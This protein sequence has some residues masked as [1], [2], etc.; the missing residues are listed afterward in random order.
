MTLLQAGLP[1]LCL[2]FKQVYVLTHRWIL[3]FSGWLHP[4][5]RAALLVSSCRYS[6]VRTAAVSCSF[7]PTWPSSSPDPCTLLHPRRRF[8]HL[9]SCVRMNWDQLIT[10]SQTPGTWSSADGG[11]SPSDVASEL[12]SHLVVSHLLFLS[13]TLQSVFLCCFCQPD[14]SVLRKNSPSVPHCRTS[15]SAAGSLSRL[16]Q[17]I[18][19]SIFKIRNSFRVLSVEQDINTMQSQTFTTSGVI[20]WF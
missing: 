18:K 20:T 12:E 16:A 4:L 7:R 13:R 19:Y 17:W 8:L 1:T 6:S 10:V 9:P 3:C 15:P 2:Y 5:M 14:C 11:L